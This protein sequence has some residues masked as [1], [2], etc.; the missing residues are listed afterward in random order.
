MKS[1]RHSFVAQ[2]IVFACLL[3]LPF[4]IYSQTTGCPEV[5]ASIA[6]GSPSTVC[7]GNCTNLTTTVQGTLGTASYSVA[8]IPYN[9]TSFTAGT[10]VLIGIDDWFSPVL[11]IPFNFCY[12][13]TSYNQLVIGANGD[14]TFD[15]TQANNTDPWSQSPGPI[16]NSSY[17]TNIMAPYVD[18]DPAVSG[19]ITWAIYGTAPCRQFVINWD[20]VPDY[21]CNNLIATQQCV[22]NETTN[23]I[24]VY[25]Q[26]RPLCASWNAGAGILGIQNT[27][28]TS[29]VTVPGRNSTQW[30]AT[31]EGWRFS[32]TGAPSYTLNWTNAA[33]TSIGTT[34]TINV[35]PTTTTTYTANLKNTSCD[36]SVINLTSNVT[37][38]VGGTAVTVTPVTTTL[39][40]GGTVSLTAAGATT[41]S[42]SPAGTLSSST[43]ATVVATPPNGT[44][45]YT[46]T[47]TSGGCTGTAT[48]TVTVGAAPVTV[49]P[50]TS[51][52]CPGG[53]VTLTAAGATTYSWSPAGTLSASTGATVVA[54]PTGTTTYTVTGT[55]GACTG[56]ATSTITVGAPPVLTTSFVGATCGQSDGSATVTAPGAGPF[57][58]SWSP[59]AG[60]AAT[61]TNIP[62]G[63]YSVTVTSGGCSQTATVNVSNTGGPTMV[64]SAFTNVT[65]FG[66]NNGSITATV[67][68]G[69]APLTYSWTPGAGI[70]NV[71]NG[72]TFGLYTVSVTD[73][74]GCKVSASQNINQPAVLASTG[75][76]TNIT[77]NGLCNGVANVNAT[78]GTL[79]YTYA[80]APSGGAAA[81][82]TALCAGNYTCTMTDSKGCT[83]TQIDSV[84]QPLAL[85]I[86]VAGIN[87]S[88]N[89]GCNGQLICIPAGGT[90]PYTYSWNSGCTTPSCNNICAGNYN[91][92]V[93]DAS[94]CTI[95]GT[96]VVGQPAAMALT[97]FPKS[98][99]CNL[100]D[101]SDS[102]SVAGG[103]VP[104]TYSWTP[105]PGSATPG[106]DNLV[107]GVYTITVTDSKNCQVHDTSTVHN[108]PGITVSILASVNDSCFNGIN[109]SATAG[110][111]G[112][113]APYTYSWV[114]GGNT[115]ATA[116]GLGAGFYTCTIKDASGCFNA[117]TIQIT[118]P[119]AVTVTTT[120]ATICISQNTPLIAQG[121]GGTPGYTYAWINSA[122]A[123]VTPPVSPLV[124]SS[125]MVVCTD[126]NQCASTLVNVQV[127]VNPSLTVAV[128]N[129]TSICPGNSTALFASATGGDNQY[130]YVWTPGAN[131]TG[132]NTATPTATPAIATTYTVHVTDN[133]GTPSDSAFVTITLYAP[134]IISFTAT[135]TIGC[136]PLCANFQATSTPACQSA[137][138][139]FGDGTT[140]SGCGVIHHCY[141]SDT[142]AT[143]FTVGLTIQ[144]IHGCTSV[145][146]KPGYMTEFP[147]PIAAFNA[148]PAVA[149]IVNPSIAFTNT[150]IGANKWT[151]NFGDVV[152]AGDTLQNTHYTYPDTGCYRVT[153]YVQ[154]AF[155]CKDS[156]HSEVCIQP[157]Y[158]F[159]APDAFTPNGDGH[160]DVWRPNGIG[161][162]FSQ[163]TLYIFDRWG[164]E[165][166]EST[167][168]DE[169]WDGRANHGP[170]ISQI[171]VYVYRVNVLDFQGNKHVYT[172]MLNLMK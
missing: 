159:Y 151:W 83:A 53:T 41:Y 24:D 130:T 45:T 2:L 88:C 1:G 28:Y 66:G 46:V 86:N 35:C 91:I 92:T 167:V 93:T 146:S 138:W 52:V 38:T 76:K 30:S 43:G 64:I 9:P 70:T 77:C 32:P 23:Y 6:V 100:P 145:T 152:N 8:A 56:T 69:A 163:Y 44:T 68:G 132:A 22:L 63:A 97:L 4:G 108:L 142:V 42:W 124:T 111:V 147:V 89:G 106:Y 80:W 156:T 67:T 107:P 78:G 7:P 72:L 110:V 126:A 134:P 11:N 157:E 58:Y 165:L 50:L 171:D 149:S 12:Y 15:L 29:C 113:A 128:S 169:G 139:V 122:G 94:G 121:A 62:A 82:A 85:T 65:C 17:P 160:N 48:A 33:G 170:N 73:A 49:T 125:Y 18:I 39:C 118:Q 31:N 133:C 79:P 127:T 98:A 101:G 154:N 75:T 37:V 104:Y 129:D 84:L 135:D 102:V 143:F 71:E 162:D 103:T 116:T 3:F 150:S 74:N 114:P 16:P 81:S 14:I 140:G 112:G 120:A 20:V 19:N 96:T 166:Y 55:A 27:T 51:T 123:P 47:G 36:G 13:G 87:A 148:T 34:P 119:T 168:W 21:S 164:N 115:T 153:L 144:D 5:A 105:T 25:I 40:N 161:I 141:P 61:L 131:L 90:S 26:S 172:G 137:Q 10:A 95:P 109:G 60:T 54:T 136:S 155:G 117:Q 99:N 59:V 158:E 57:T